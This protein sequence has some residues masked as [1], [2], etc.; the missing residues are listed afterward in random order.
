LYDGKNAAL[1]AQDSETG[2]ILA[3]VGSRD[4]FDKTVDGN[5]NVAAQGLRQPGSA[6]KPFVYLTA[7]KKGYS[8]KTIIMIPLLN[9]YL[10]ILIAHLKSHFNPK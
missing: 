10:V 9:L 5:F 1:V 6:L 8:P 2:Q 3:L 4:Y 7:F